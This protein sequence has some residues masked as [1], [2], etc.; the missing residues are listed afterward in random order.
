MSDFKC[1]SDEYQ[2]L[3]AEEARAKKDAAERAVQDAQQR[4]LRTRKA[5]E[6]VGVYRYME[7]QA[8]AMKQEGFACRYYRDIVED[9]AMA[10]ITFV[11]MKGEA[12][13]DRSKFGPGFAGDL[14]TH[15]LQIESTGDEVRFRRY[16]CYRSGTVSDSKALSDLALEDV[17]K[18]F[19]HFVRE[20]FIDR[21]VHNDKAAD[22]PV[23]SPR[24]RG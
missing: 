1:I 6:E 19:E 20:A 13:E 3:Q 23:N 21:T 4:V 2:N 10:S 9:R 14:N 11:A 15:S 12:I 18:Q 8:E 17:Q 22:Q 16:S 7:E 24:N 5:F